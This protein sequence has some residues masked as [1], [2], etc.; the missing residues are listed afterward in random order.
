MILDFVK[1]FLT[2]FLLIKVL[3][4]FVPKNVFQKYIAFFSGVILVI[5]LLYPILQGI[6]TEEVFLEKLEYER[7]EEELYK[8]A[9]NAAKLEESGRTV[10]EDYYGEGTEQAGSGDITIET[11]KIENVTQAGGRNE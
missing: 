7:W 4:Y 5:G 1:S 6:G 11:I 8:I 2:L 10:M 9:Q 3:L